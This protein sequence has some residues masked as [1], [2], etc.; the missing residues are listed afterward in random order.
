MLGHN[1]GGGGIFSISRTTVMAKLL[2]ATSLLVTMVVPSVQGAQPQEC[3]LYQ[4]AHDQPSPT[5]DV[6]GEYGEVYISL[7]LLF[8][9]STA[10]LDIYIGNI[11]TSDS[12]CQITVNKANGT[13]HG[14]CFQEKEIPLKFSEVGGMPTIVLKRR[15]ILL[16]AQIEGDTTDIKVLTLKTPNTDMDI[17]VQ[18]NSDTKVNTAFNCPS[19]CFQF[20]NAIIHSKEN[21]TLSAQKTDFGGYTNTAGFITVLYGESLEE[22]VTFPFTYP[23]NDTFGDDDDEQKHFY[24]APD[25]KIHNNSEISLELSGSLIGIDI[26]EI[27]GSVPS[28]DSYF[29]FEDMD[30]ILWTICEHNQVKDSSTV[31]PSTYQT[32]IRDGRSRKDVTKQLYSSSTDLVTEVTEHDLTI[33]HIETNITGVITND[34]EVDI[35]TLPV[36][37]TTERFTEGIIFIELSCKD[38]WDT[39]KPHCTLTNDTGA[40]CNCA[41]AKT[42]GWCE[43]SD[44]YPD[45]KEF[46]KRSCGW[47]PDQDLGTIGG[48]SGEPDAYHYS[49]EGGAVESDSMNAGV[50]VYVLVGIIVAVFLAVLIW[51]LLKHR[52]TASGAIDIEGHSDGI[53]MK[54]TID[55]SKENTADTEMIQKQDQDDNTQGTDNTAYQQQ[56]DIKENTQ[57]SDETKKKSVKFDA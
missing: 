14:N 10:V 54:E 39:W 55:K 16:T 12:S 29:I 13:I 44:S 56:D 32:A 9:N 40:A 30:T 46:C 20:N 26:P 51:L 48:I 43:N 28:L 6:A 41:E 22:N 47:C 2:L 38:T 34:T 18:V 15:A 24:A 4:V 49:E 11:S 52:K 33:V 50:I 37:R 31:T 25:F 36:G 8:D 17:Q 42:N 1:R 57:L 53:E 23:I 3:R 35:T 27:I 7:D 19:K 21:L 45:I 5:I